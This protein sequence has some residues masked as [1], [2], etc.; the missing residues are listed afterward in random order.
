MIAKR[1]V[2]GMVGLGFLL[3]G[4]TAWAI[5]PPHSGPKNPQTCMA[6]HV[7]HSA[8]GVSLTTV[9]GNA[10]LCISCHTSGG[11][12]SNKPF[13][14]TMQ[15]VPGVSGS[16][17]RWDGAMP[18][19]SSPSNTYGLRPASSVTTT[20][21]RNKL[22]NKFSGVAVCSVCHNPHS[23]ASAAWDVF[24]GSLYRPQGRRFRCGKRFRHHRRRSS[25]PPNRPSGP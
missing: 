16:S 5:D 23:S 8:A 12:A 25:T 1:I 19:V 20:V 4:G 14:S 15:A 13:S 21:I 7:A 22:T 9:N 2:S 18:A 11:T 3:I 10:N 24:S 6:C 17:H